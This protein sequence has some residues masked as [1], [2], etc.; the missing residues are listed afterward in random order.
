MGIQL[1]MQMK[2]IQMLTVVKTKQIWVVRF[3]PNTLSVKHSSLDDVII[4]SIASEEFIN[5]T[6]LWCAKT[7][8]H[9][10]IIIHNT[11]IKN[12]LFLEVTKST[13]KQTQEKHLN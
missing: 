7:F 8:Q 12:Y 1:I 6:I 9:Y 4:K 10:S 2:Y 3:V 11:K 13:N 5:L